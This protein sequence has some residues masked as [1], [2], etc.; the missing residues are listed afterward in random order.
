MIRNHGFMFV[1][2]G[3]VL[4][5]CA[6]PEQPADATPA[7]DT[8]VMPD[9]NGSPTDPGPIAPTE[10]GDVVGRV[11]L[12][13][14]SLI[15]MESYPVQVNVLLQGDLPTPCHRFGYTLTELEDEPGFSLE[16]YA[17]AKADDVCVQML[18]PFEESIRL[19]LEGKPD[20]AYKVY[21]DGELIGE[22]NYPG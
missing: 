22:F 16:L 15:V 20:G 21:V 12:N 4:A 5:A 7:P 11:Y 3:L 2:I 14:A 18:Q 9:Q 6:A 13:S 8:P 19:P 10:P 1:V 17:T